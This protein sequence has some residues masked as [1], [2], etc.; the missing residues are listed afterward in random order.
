MEKKQPEPK[1]ADELRAEALEKIIRDAQRST[2]QARADLKAE[3]ERSAV[4][5]EIPPTQNQQT[6]Y[7]PEETPATAIPQP[8][9]EKITAPKTPEEEIRSFLTENNLT[10]L[11]PNSY[12]V[13][14]S[15]LDIPQ[16][17][18]VV[19]DLKRRIVDIVKADGQTQYSE[20]L[21]KRLAEDADPTLQKRSGMIAKGIRTISTSIAAS[22][23]KE[24]DLKEAEGEVFQRIM[25]SP[26][27]R[28]IIK[29][30]LALLTKMTQE[31]N[32]FIGHNTGNI[33]INYVD[34]NEGPEFENLNRVIFNFT[35]MPYE[36]GQEDGT[37][38][39]KNFDKAKAEYEEAVGKVLEIKKSKEGAE[40]AINDMSEVV[41]A[42]QMEQLLNTHPQFQKAL[43][44]F[45]ESAGGKEMVK[46]V[47]N[48]FQ[49]ITGG[50]NWTNKFLTA[51]GFAARAGI[52]IATVATGA[53]VCGA[54]GMPI[55]GGA[56]GYWRGKLRAEN[57]L[58]DREKA[59]RHG[60]KDETKGR[61]K[62]KMV[63]VISLNMGLQKMMERVEIGSMDQREHA[64]NVGKL[65]VIINY[66]SDEIEKGEVNFG[67]AKS[68]LS[69]QF[70]LVNNL[71]RAVILIQ[72][73][74]SVISGDVESR[75]NSLISMEGRKVDARISQAQEAFIKK[76]AKKGAIMGAT[77]AAGGYVFRMFGEHMGW[78]GHA[79]APSG[80]PVIEKPEA[81]ET[82][83]EGFLEHAK[84]ALFG[85]ETKTFEDGSIGRLNDHGQLMDRKFPDGSYNQYDEHEKL[86]HHF[87]PAGHETSI[88]NEETL[89]LEK[90]S[91]AGFTESTE[92]GQKVWTGKWQ[93]GGIRK[94]YENGEVK[95][96]DKDGNM[97]YDKFM[98]DE[99]AQGWNEDGLNIHPTHLADETPVPQ[100]PTTVAPVEHP[101][102]TPV[103]PV[104]TTTAET[105][106]PTTTIP[107]AETPVSIKPV[108]TS[109]INDIHLAQHSENLHVEQMSAPKFTET[110]TAMNVPHV[111]VPANLTYETLTD[112]TK[113][114]YDHGKIVMKIFPNGDTESYWDNGKVFTKT[115]ADKHT[116]QEY[117]HDGKIIKQYILDEK[118][119]AKELPLDSTPETPVPV[120]PVDTAV[121]DHAETNL[122][123]HTSKIETSPENTGMAA[124]GD[125]SHHD[126]ESARS[127]VLGAY[128]S[129]H[130]ESGA[131]VTSEGYGGHNIAYSS[132][133]K[134][135]YLK[136][137][138][139]KG[140]VE[141]SR[142]EAGGNIIFDSNPQ[143]LGFAPVGQQ[144]HMELSI[145]EREIFQAMEHDP[146]FAKNPFHLDTN[147]L[148]QT[149]EEHNKNV[150]EI[151]KYN[152][153]GMS[154]WKEMKD[155]KVSDLLKNNHPDPHDKLTAYVQKL[156]LAS[157]K[158]KPEG[159]IVRKPETIEHYMERALQKVAVLHKLKEMEVK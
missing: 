15:D 101:V 106:A 134:A 132:A 63:D 33:C 6:V 156:Y 38:H 153:K 128:D 35:Q 137:L 21:K 67:D 80:K 27:G 12:G 123:E 24:A 145:K 66:T 40:K 61:E 47:G 85:Y 94:I 84:H 102:E 96:F 133:P 53:T 62:G 29:N 136:D 148:I 76:Q 151:F 13:V 79:G 3:R 68:S 117:D 124:F 125:T 158:L 64:E 82:N 95:T 154:L 107:V 98:S 121:A 129:H 55:V 126:V 74:S 86:V 119:N 105:P 91:G 18:K 104:E 143:R 16:Q 108:D 100:T 9:K 17:L 59:A 2:E 4:T 56:I 11:L 120:K 99:K 41:N 58:E 152:D 72:E 140:Y 78:W 90:V 115:F 77:A 54:L 149:Y 103:T 34:R 26:E 118:G 20:D 51:G 75:I 112:G 83:S 49:T 127:A 114:T 81:Q 31:Q 97:T 92:N 25:N 1:T 139:T 144:M 32:V 46:T 37:T 138:G 70:N 87:D 73:N 28:E 57:T 109:E 147:R 155:D 52:K 122:A 93:D 88:V 50:K 30:D 116:W 135:V 43:D 146:E 157:N 71:N 159:G 69:N 22:I 89:R 42:V 10:E 45:G 19:R 14:F 8:K 44:E 48:F 39:K 5:P 141:T 23:T 36:W 60:K 7:T 142:G 65:S 111:S 131:V 150:L 113:V 130:A 110:E